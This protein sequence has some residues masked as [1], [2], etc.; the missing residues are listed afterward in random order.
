MSIFLQEINSLKRKLIDLEIRITLAEQGAVS[1]SWKASMVKQIASE[2]FNVA[3]PAIS[4]VPRMEHIVK[5]R[6]CAMI[7]ASEVSHL[8]DFRIEKLFNKS[9]GI[10]DNAR[11]WIQDRRE[12]SAVFES[13]FKEF[14]EK[15][16]EALK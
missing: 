3:L 12:T 16:L 15:C 7:V 5:A 13:E 9:H 8:S 4:G 11:R 6:Y 14:R 2:Y 1:A 10:M